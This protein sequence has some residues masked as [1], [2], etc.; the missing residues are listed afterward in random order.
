ME[1]GNIYAMAKLG[2]I[3]I[4]GQKDIKKDEK[5]GLEYLKLSSE[6][7]N[8][9][10]DLAIQFYED[11][12][13]NMDKNLAIRAGYRCFSS[14]FSTIA[15]DRNRLDAYMALKIYRSTGKEARKAEL[16]K[17]GKYIERND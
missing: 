1:H 2:H 14:I 8:E 4:W 11:F 10:A 17:Q 5:L 6:A 9:Y 15:T 12:Q 13:K 3:Y 16:T 7:G